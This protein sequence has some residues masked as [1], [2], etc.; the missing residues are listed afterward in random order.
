MSRNKQVVD[1]DV[2]SKVTFDQEGVERIGYVIVVQKKPEDTMFLCAYV[3]MDGAE[4][5]V[6][7]WWVDQDELISVEE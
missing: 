1:A 3:D 2:G 7:G 4:P 5:E 6:L